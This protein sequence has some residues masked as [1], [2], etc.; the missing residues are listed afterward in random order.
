MELQCRPKYFI[1]VPKGRVNRDLYVSST[2]QIR[3]AIRFPR[4]IYSSYR[5][6]IY[7][8]Y[9]SMCRYLVFF[10]FIIDEFIAHLWRCW[11]V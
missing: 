2:N 1:T 6:N 7:Q 5:L 3:V 9:S 10:I 4:V 11:S 8:M